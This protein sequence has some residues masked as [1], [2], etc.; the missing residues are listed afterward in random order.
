MS[1]NID[2]AT[3]E[4]STTEQAVGKW[5]DGKT[6]YR[7]VWTGTYSATAQSYTTLF[8]MSGVSAVV[9]VGGQVAGRDAT[10]AFGAE[11]RTSADSPILSS[12]VL[13]LSSGLQ[14]RVYAA[15][16]ANNLPYAVWIE[17]TK[18]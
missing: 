18:A 12:Y 6:I 11:H 15:S 3:F 2:F 7:K 5:V 10:V 8:S 16:A 4:Y 17:Y 14:A 9:A 1:W 13:V